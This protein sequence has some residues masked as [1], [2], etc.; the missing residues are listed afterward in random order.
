MSAILSILIMVLVVC[1]TCAGIRMIYRDLKYPGKR[2]DAYSGH[3]PEQRL[4]LWHAD[5]HD[6][7]TGHESGNDGMLDVAAAV[8]DCLYIG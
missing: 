4:M 6:V 7:A 8:L 3:D 2:L 5:H 1:E